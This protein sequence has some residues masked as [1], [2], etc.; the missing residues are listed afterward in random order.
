MSTI[1]I[2]NKSYVGESKE[3]M[4]LRQR[5]AAYYKKNQTEIAAGCI[6]MGGNASSVNLYRMM[7]K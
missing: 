6:L 2:R 3:K 1:A 4:S 5:L 7:N